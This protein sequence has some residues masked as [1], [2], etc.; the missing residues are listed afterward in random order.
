MSVLT[1]LQRTIQQLHDVEL[2]LDVEHY[3]VDDDVRREIPGAVE[4]LPEQLFVRDEGEDGMEI[5]LYIAPQIIGHLQQDDPHRRLHGG[6]LEDYCIALEG[7]SHF[8]FL[9]WRA[10]MNWPV[11]ALE[12]EIQAE[13]DKFIAAWLLL[14]AQGQ[15][16]KQTAKPL[17]R[18]L[19]SSYALRDGLSSEEEER[20][21]TATR[22]AS[23]YVKTL[24][25]RFSGDETE[26]RIRRDARDFYRRG[27]PEKMRA[28]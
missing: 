5:A 4:G 22:V 13:V 10:N 21:H 6:N 3:I 17:M 9:A 19:F 26:E 7:V 15:G 20:Y 25:R 24:V 11:S 23:Q 8:V 28:A 18:Q 16:R 1:T 2:E 14:D 27:L 12:M